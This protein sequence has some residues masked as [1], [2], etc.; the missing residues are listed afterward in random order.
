MPDNAKTIWITDMHSKNYLDVYIKEVSHEVTLEF[1][2]YTKPEVDALFETAKKETDEAIEA[3]APKRCKILI[4]FDAPTAFVTDGRFA[5]CK[6]YK[7]PFTV[8]V[9]V[10]SATNIG[11]PDNQHG[12]DY[13]DEILSYGG[14]FA[15]YSAYDKPE[16]DASI[17]NG[18]SESVVLFEEYIQ[19]ALDAAETIGIYHPV[20]WFSRSQRTGTA[21]NQALINKGFKICR[22][23][24]YGTNESKELFI[25][26]SQ[27]SN[28]D[29]T[30]FNI[31]GGYEV[32]EDSTVAV[33]KAHIDEAIAQGKDFSVFCHKICTDGETPRQGVGTTAENLESVLLYI[34]Q[35]IDAGLCEGVTCRDYYTEL[36]PSDGM[37][38]NY[39]N[40]Y[41]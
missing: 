34:R 30:R 2:A 1:K 10:N 38:R 35:K 5:L 17:Y 14:D 12:H 4:N 3:I 23:Y 21:M 33:M 20:A 26:R 37:A 32:G 41:S 9:T 25:D 22:G 31:S 28:S 6:K 18:N 8:N 40:A 16:E 39:G 27:F 36:Y 7:L 19:K 13:I 24:K 29:P 15:L 11:Y